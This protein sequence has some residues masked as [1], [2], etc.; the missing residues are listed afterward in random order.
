MTDYILER[1]SIGSVV[2][3]SLGDQDPEKNPAYADLD[4]E[5][6]EKVALR[7]NG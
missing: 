2:A 4:D 6:F 3:S 7:L 1:A 5:A